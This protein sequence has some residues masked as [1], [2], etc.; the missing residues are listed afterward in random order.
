MY[1]INIKTRVANFCKR[2]LVGPIVKY[3]FLKLQLQKKYRILN[4]NS[5]AIGHL[6]IDID[7]FLKERINKNLEFRGVLLA[8]RGRVA[9]EAL[10]DLWAQNQG[11]VRVQNALLCFLLD[12]LRVYEETAYDCSNYCAKDGQPAEVFAVYRDFKKSGP[13]IA[14]EPG[15]LKRA[16]SLFASVFPGADEARIVVLHSRDYKYDQVKQNV[17]LHTQNYRNSDINT[18]A[19][20]L[21]FL[22]QRNYS[23]I[24]IGEYQNKESD[25][26][27][28][29]MTIRGVSKEDSDLLNVYVTSICCALLGSASG[30]SNLAA[31]WNRPVF[32]TNI[33]PY[34]FLRPHFAEGM[35]LPKLLSVGNKILN[36]KEI[37]DNKYH[38]YRDDRLYAKSGLEISTNVSSDCLDDFKE[39][40]A[41]FVERDERIL[42][43]LRESEQQRMYAQQCPK[44]SYDRDAQS[45]IPR[46]FF[47][48]YDLV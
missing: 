27:N 29:Y 32:L 44:D 12:Y 37:F 18:Y 20:I 22:R 33:L 28:C 30:A 41:A 43:A 38:W 42:R 15:M 45:L 19:E 46:R 14:W 21:A 48:K 39:F 9:N 10:S 11:I 40:F 16:Q 4:T 31:I 35:A 13:M 25:S 36:V 34:A 24:R 26:D 2:K 47:E 1:Q 17:N 7:C 23:I 6:C 3:I 5:A 8:Q